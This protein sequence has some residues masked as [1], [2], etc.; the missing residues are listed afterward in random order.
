M[1][2]LAIFTYDKKNFFHEMMQPN[3]PY[4]PAAEYLLHKDKRI[5]LVSWRCGALR[6]ALDFRSK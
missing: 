1:N 4:M 2:Q 5:V 6:G 3:I